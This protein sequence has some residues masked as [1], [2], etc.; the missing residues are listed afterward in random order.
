MIVAHMQGLDT[1]GSTPTSWQRWSSHRLVA[2]AHTVSD[3]DLKDPGS[4]HLW[5]GRGLD[6][7]VAAL[8]VTKKPA[9]NDRVYA[10][11]GHPQFDKLRDETLCYN[12]IRR[13]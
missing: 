2:G 1:F 9:S 7:P 8:F 3:P 11:S 4:E 10:W 13:S 12:S 6:M 5:K